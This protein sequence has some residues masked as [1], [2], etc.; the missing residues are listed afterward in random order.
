[1]GSQ[2]A[3]PLI[4]GQP[5]DNR[6]NYKLY[7]FFKSMGSQKITGLDGQQWLHSRFLVVY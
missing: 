5:K 6:N 7:K 3:T 2:K 1:M 4:N